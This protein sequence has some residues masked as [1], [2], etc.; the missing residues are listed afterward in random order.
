VDEAGIDH[1]LVCIRRFFQEQAGTGPVLQAPG[2]AV[3]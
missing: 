2:S 3:Y 1:A